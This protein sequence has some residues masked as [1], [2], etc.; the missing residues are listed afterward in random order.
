M[1]ELNIH[2]LQNLID[3]HD[4]KS[5]VETGSG[6]GTGIEYA[7]QHKFLNL[8]SVE[9]IE[10]L[11]NK[12]VDKFKDN[13]L[14]LINDNSL[15][16]LKTIL[17]GLNSS[18]TI[19][20]LDAHFPGADFHYNSYDHLK[21]DKSLHAPLMMELDIIKT[22]RPN[23]RDVFII[24]D[25]QLYEDGNYELSCPVNFVDQ[26]GN[27]SGDIQRKLYEYFGQSHDFKKC[28]THQGSLILT[29]KFHNLS[30]NV[31]LINQTSGLG[32]I[33]F[34]QKIAKI[35][36]DSGYK[37]IWPVDSENIRSVAH[38]QSS[39]YI[40][41]C[42][43]NEDFIQRNLY[44][45]DSS[46]VRNDRK[47]SIN[48][49]KFIYLPFLY[50]F[51]YF[52]N[53]VSYN[54]QNNQMPTLIHPNMALKY[55]MC[56]IDYTDWSEYFKFTRDLHKEDALCDR[57]GLDLDEPYTLVNTHYGYYGY[58]VDIPT[59]PVVGK[60]VLFDKIDDYS[61]FDWCSIIENASVIHTV[62][63]GLCFLIEKLETTDQLYVYNRGVNESEKD[64]NLN[65]N[66]FSKKWKCI[67]V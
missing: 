21:E 61:I 29:P 43:L 18:P 15:N 19:F 27:R 34:L 38:L 56:D 5:F 32:D 41:Y 48:S 6:I 22:F 17:S 52:H 51:E 44:Y 53:G 9:Y 3:N 67:H 20:W 66:M 45:P 24:D 50:A 37:I 12:C 46:S 59:Y 26:Y 23:S 35:W 2:N 16:G 54:G 28:L 65:M 11:Y 55:N 39:S 36:A 62:D 30:E 63:T 47:S 42:D 33:F 57:L 49:E 40:D 64:L 31:C 14:S 10:D 7:L 25:W 13:R 58:S 1:G 4:C 8:Y 60:I